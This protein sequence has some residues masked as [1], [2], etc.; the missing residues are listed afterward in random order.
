MSQQKLT[1]YEHILEI[2]KRIFHV[3]V[4]FILGSIAGFVFNH[5]IQTALIDPLGQQL[6]YTSPMGGFSFMFN[7]SLFAGAMLAIPF[8]V[9]H[10][11]KFISPTI[12]NNRA[13]YAFKLLGASILLT[14]AGVSFAYNVS[15]P[16]T[17]NFLTGF[18]SDIISSLIS[19]S[20]YLSFIKLY[21][22][23]FALIFQIPLILLII[24]NIKPINPQKMLKSQKYVVVFSFIAAAIISPTPDA[25]NQTLMAA[26]MI[27][28]YELS[29][30]LIWLVNRG[31]AGQAPPKTSTGPSTPFDYL[32]SMDEPQKQLS[33]STQSAV[34][35]ASAAGWGHSTRPRSISQ[36][37]KSISGVLNEQVHAKATNRIKQVPQQ[38]STLRA[39]HKSIDIKTKG[40]ASSHSSTNMNVK[41]QS[42]RV[43]RPEYTSKRPTYTSRARY[44]DTRE[45]RMKLL[46]DFS[47]R[48][49]ARA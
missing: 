46:D 48:Q 36:N 9:L 33:P 25:L 20:E 39:S 43:K 28:L 41:P 16:P 29:I 4:V 24:N 21:L 22:T 23:A 26:P 31:S 12:G 6:Y 17:L 10:V 38:A 30:G 37:K 47:A 35:L 5:E 15:L 34:P 49:P 2:R 40:F 32:A 14:I 8:C 11:I 44:D 1:F 7:I 19:T 18:D 42:V 45:R 27:L 13:S 3:L